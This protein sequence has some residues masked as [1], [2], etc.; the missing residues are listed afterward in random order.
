MTVGGKSL[1][2]HLE[3]IDHKEAILYLEQLVQ[4]VEKLSVTNIKHL[5]AIVLGRIRPTDTSRYRGVPVTVV[6]MYHHI[7]GK[8]L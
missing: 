4:S 2:D 7:H 8:F 5:H 3:A 6:I 1:Q